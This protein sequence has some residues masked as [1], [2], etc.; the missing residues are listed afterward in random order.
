MWKWPFPHSRFGHFQC[1]KWKSKTT[2]VSKHTPNLWEIQPQKPLLTTGKS[3]SNE[4]KWEKG[5]LNSG[6]WSLEIQFYIHIFARKWKNLTWWINSLLM[7]VLHPCVTLLWGQSLLR[8]GWYNQNRWSFR[9]VLTRGGGSIS[10]H[11]FMSD[12][13]DLKICYI[14]FRKWGRS[15]RPFGAFPKI[16]QFWIGLDK[17]F[18]NQDFSRN[19]LSET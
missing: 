10:N 7:Y 15:Q 6:F 3:F 19:K 17:V 11:I 14:I 13:L 8:E 5:P 2:S 4:E 9:K 18:G 16:H 12:I 1:P